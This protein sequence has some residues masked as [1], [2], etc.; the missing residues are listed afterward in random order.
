MLTPEQKNAIENLII[1]AGYVKD[2]SLYGEEDG[3]I[4]D[5]SILTAEKLLGKKI[6]SIEEP[7]QSFVIEEIK[8]RFSS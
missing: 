1:L 4:I 8:K 7:P 6:S 2:G 5:K 3:K